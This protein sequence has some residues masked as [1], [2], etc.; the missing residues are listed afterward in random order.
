MM[1][2]NAFRWLLFLTMAC[3]PVLQ[4]QTAVGG[5]CREIPR[6][7]ALP[8]VCAPPTSQ[9]NRTALPDS[10][11]LLQVP[12]GTSLRVAVDQKVRIARAGQPVTGRLTEPIYAFDQIVIPA[13]SL[14]TGRVTSVHSVTAMKKTMSYINGNFSP[15]HEYDL[16]FDSLTL[17]GGEQRKI[18]TS[19]SPGIAQAVHLVA[20]GTAEKKKNAAARAAEN[21][22]MEA[23]GKVH[24]TIDEIKSPG[25]V[26]R[27]KEMLLA[28]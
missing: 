1:A 27:L 19:V 12:A 10:L 4:G 9:V 14:V 11:I 25:K 28:Q 22:K 20:G 21:A 3:A 7:D 18:S 2:D 24:D 15:V 5:G 23:E 16:E 13:G 8:S 17:P 26:E 6:E